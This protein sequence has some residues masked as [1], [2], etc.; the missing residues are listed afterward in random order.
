MAWL[1]QL[2]IAWTDAESADAKHIIYWLT[3]RD[4]MFLDC[5]TSLLYLVLEFSFDEFIF[6]KEESLMLGWHFEE[7]QE[8]ILCIQNYNFD[9]GIC[10]I[11]SF[12]VFFRY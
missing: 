12:V 11:Y 9:D 10:E 5:A 4:W 7:D 3:F 8:G 1:P 2:F 6:V